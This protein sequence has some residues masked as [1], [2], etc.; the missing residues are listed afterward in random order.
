MKKIQGPGIFL[1]QFLRDE[2]PFNTLEGITKWVAELGYK[3]VQIPSWDARV[4]DLE[5]AAES[6]AYCDEYKG[7]LADAGVV[8]IELGSYLQGQVLAF[9]PAYEVGFE[10]FYPAGLN[11]KERVEW[12]ADQ[13][14]KS[15]QASVNLGT[16]NISVMSG[17]LLWHTIYPWPQRPEGL[18]DQAFTELAKRW[19]PLA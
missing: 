9:H 1:A 11:A 5:K 4:F 18:V 8:P 15:V 12:A 7:K 17:G 16:K 6:K 3:G 14:R 19:R 13:L 10:P 2:E